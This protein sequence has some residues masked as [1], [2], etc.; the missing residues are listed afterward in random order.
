MNIYMKSRNSLQYI[1]FSFE[2]YHSLILI[3]LFPFAKFST[4]YYVC[5]KQFSLNSEVLFLRPS[6]IKNSSKASTLLS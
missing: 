5:I 1:E 6:L 2:L 4:K 3:L